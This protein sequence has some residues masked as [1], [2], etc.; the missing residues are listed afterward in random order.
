MNLSDFRTRLQDVYGN[1]LSSEDTFYNRIINDAYM[2]LCSY[3]DWWWL[4]DYEVL[5]FSAPVVSKDFDCV[6]ATADITPEAPAQSVT[7]AYSLGWCHTGAHTYRITAV[8]GSDPWTVT[9][10]SDFIEASDAY[11]CTFWNDTLTIGTTFDHAISVLPRIDP[12]RK[13][14]RHIDLCDIESY[15]PDVSTL[16][17]DAAQAYTIYQE[18]TIAEGRNRIRI[19][20]PPDEVAEY[21]L[22]YIQAP[23]SM[24]ND[25]ASALVPIKFENVLADL[26]RLELL[27]VTGAD[28][29]EIAMWE[30]E[31]AKGLNFMMAEQHK[32]GHV[33][34]V[35]GRHGQ[36]Q[37]AMLPYK[38]T[39]YTVGDPI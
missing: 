35:Y 14:L 25:T 5:T 7:T 37:A 21:I 17:N 29:A 28:P 4:E 10:D 13:P 6:I 31:L 9:L 11:S 2:K 22:R 30:Q 8:D 26:A 24:A 12:N 27:K 38:L 16:E 34:R 20:P 18:S 15:G 39:N 32:R 36:R 23:G 1:T 33:Q 19:F 3:T